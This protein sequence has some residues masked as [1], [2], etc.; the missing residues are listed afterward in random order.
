MSGGCGGSLLG[1]HLAVAPRCREAL[2]VADRFEVRAAIDVS[3]GL[4]LD[5]SRMMAASGTGAVIDLAAV[6]IHPD[7]V[8]MAADDGR[9]PLEHALG[10]GEDFEL[11]LAMPPDDARRLA[12][13]GPRLVG[14]P[15]TVV[16]EVTAEGGLRGRSADG[17]L[18][19]LVPRGY[20]H[21]F[22]G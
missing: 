15:F 13:E 21:D 16:G 14:T 5:C 18:A 3:D 9:S 19:A 11:L 2:V 6:P 10:D 4:T 12:A 1:R 17:S 22:D 8:R 7:A 20:E